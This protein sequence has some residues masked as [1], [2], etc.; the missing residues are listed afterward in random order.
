MP[1]RAC[2]RHETAQ[3]Q[4]AT[5]P[6]ATARQQRARP[7]QPNANMRRASG[8]AKAT[9]QQQARAHRASAQILNIQ[10]ATPTP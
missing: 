4:A 1:P 10:V 3:G 8:H 9:V 5:A 7:K 2:Q 6:P